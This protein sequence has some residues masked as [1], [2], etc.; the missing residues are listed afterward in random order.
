MLAP[1]HLGIVF[2]GLQ[3][4]PGAGWKLAEVF[5]VAGHV[6]TPDFVYF[7]VTVGLSV[8]VYEVMVHFVS[9]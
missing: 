9:E 3:K 7:M 6:V 1:I 5:P 2:P 4:C 8:G